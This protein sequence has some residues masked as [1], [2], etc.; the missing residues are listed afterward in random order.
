MASKKIARLSEEA[1][2]LSPEFERAVLYGSLEELIADASEGN[3]SSTN[4]VLFV[5]MHYL[6][7]N[8][9]DM[10]IPA[11]DRMP[12]ILR[13]YLHDALKKIVKGESADVALNLKKKGRPDYW[14]FM[15]KRLGGYLV[16]QALVESELGVDA[17]AGEARSFI[18]DQAHAGLLQG[19][20]RCF[21]GKDLPE[22]QTFRN[23]YYHEKDYLEKLHLQY[24]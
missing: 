1:R 3:K 15:A 23:W 16:Y 12:K 21:Q 18:Q 4:E 8:R 17:A 24:P 5:A 19:H 2:K 6:H 10:D 22:W 20:W 13:K 14:G 11:T 9:T 7:P